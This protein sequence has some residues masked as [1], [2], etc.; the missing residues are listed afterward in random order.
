MDTTALPNP[1][2][3]LFHRW[4]VEYNP[5][6]L[7]SAALVLV[8]VHLLYR[9]L[10]KAGYLLG[11]LG[12]PAIAEIYGWTLVGGAA[13]LTRIGLRRP[14][15]LLALLAALFQ[16]DLTLLT[17]TSVYLGGAG[18]VALSVWLASFSAKLL[19][20]AWA[21]RLR[22]SRSALMVP[23]L[24]ALGLVMM[25]RF[26]MA[27]AGTMGSAALGAWLFAVIGAGAWSERRVTSTV[28]L[29]GW[30]E[31]VL[32]RA[33]TAIWALWSSAFVA[34]ALFAASEHRVEIGGMLPIALLLATRLLRR[35]LTV[36]ATV[37]LSLLFARWDDPKTLWLTA[38][39]AAI[40]L[41]LRAWRT[42]Q[43]TEDAPPRE[44]DE[45]GPYRRRNRRAERATKTKRHATV[46]FGPVPEAARRRLLTGS[47][48]AIYLSLWTFGW[49]GQALPPHDLLLDA[50]FTVL[51]LAA[52][53]GRRIREPLAPLALIYAHAAVATGLVAPPATRLGWGLATVGMGFALL[54]LSLGVAYRL[55]PRDDLDAPAEPNA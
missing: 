29:D 50:I 28:E 21:L 43:L 12:V 14:A 52:F 19:A 26:F 1:W 48:A 17:E 44:D 47:L 31:V 25:P 6:Y 11:Q 33:T 55:R 27:L 18:V 35:E 54:F 41:A 7:L 30:G 32:R 42:P 13:L 37:A 36:W 53:F 8:G 39:L 9:D 49:H 16:C 24:G 3:R 20:L 5:L 46:G 38:L 15:V 45:R 10:M 51:A 34:H 23:S 2:R 4:F 40:T 22:L